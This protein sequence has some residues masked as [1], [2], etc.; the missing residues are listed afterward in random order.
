VTGFEGGEL[1]LRFP[2]AGL[3]VRLAVGGGKGEKVHQYW[4]VEGGGVYVFL[5]G[6]EGGRV[7]CV[8]VPVE[9]IRGKLSGW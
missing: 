8:S 4:R 1:E 3:V 6:G 9:Y 5:K 7:H 2:R